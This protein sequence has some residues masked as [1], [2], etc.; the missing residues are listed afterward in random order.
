MKFPKTLSASVKWVIFGLV[1]LLL[2][3]L[4]HQQ[5]EFVER[6]YSRGIFQGVRYGIDQ[7]TG[8]LPFPVFYLFWIGVVVC[9]V[10]L[11]WRRPRVGTLRLKAGYWLTR[12]LGFVGFIVGLFFWMWGFNYARVP[13]KTQ[14]GLQVQPL[15]STALWQELA[16]ET[17]DLNTL[18]TALV[19]NDTNA[20]DDARFWP[21]HAEDTIRETLIQWLVN[22]NFPV[23]G[24]VRGRFIY[25]QGTLLA[26]GSSGIYWPFVVEGN[27]DAAFKCNKKHSQSC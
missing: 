25:P 9:W 6:W 27:V 8:R 2:N 3:L 4:A 22:E 19:G 12:F 15:D 23:G 7:T 26:F 14:L 13:L 10:L 11:Y 20:L 17:Q 16:R 21:T 1:T 24:R 18:R 5:P